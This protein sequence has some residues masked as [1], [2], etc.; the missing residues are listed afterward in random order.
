V[1]GGAA[2]VRLNGR[3]IAEDVKVTGCSI[4][5]LS[6]GAKLLVDDVKAFALVAP[7]DYPSA[8]VRPKGEE[9]WDV[10]MNVC[11]L[12]YNGRHAGWHCIDRCGGPRPVLGYY[13]EGLPET[14]DWEIKYMVD[15]G[16]DVQ[17]F[18]WYAESHDGPLRH[19]SYEYQLRDGFK[20][21]RYS[22][23]MKYCL[24]WEIQ[25]AGRPHSLE[26]WKKNYV[27]YLIEHHF[28]DPRYYAPDGK[29]MLA[30]F[31]GWNFPKESAFGSAAT[32][33]AAFDY[34]E[35]ELKKLGFKGLVTVSSNWHEG[36]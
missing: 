31:G 35:A 6:A 27:P 25:N 16:V 15:H 7:A 8:P 17:A 18:C 3:V 1:D 11:S 28:K 30:V 24:I 10:I 22:D 2:K 26:A 5:N 33:K 12:W 36:R 9:R 29:P 14:A 32:T 13:D 4:R 19:P 34:L 20:N 21:A 23:R